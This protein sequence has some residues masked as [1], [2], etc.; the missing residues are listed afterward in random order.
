ML[1]PDARAVL[2]G[3]FR[4][5]LLPREI[6][7]PP[8]PSLPY[9]AVRGV[10]IVMTSADMAGPL[11]LPLAIP[12]AGPL[13]TSSD[14]PV[15]VGYFALDLLQLPAMWRRPR[16]HFFYAFSGAHAA[17]PAIMAFVTPDMLPPAPAP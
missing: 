13:E 8:P 11:V 1:R 17:G 9:A 16:T 4:L 6:T 2:S 14:G 5:P 12:I 10:T 7:A 15:G 3:S